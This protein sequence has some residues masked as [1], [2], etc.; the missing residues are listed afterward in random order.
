MEK[1]GRKVLIVELL[2]R[3]NNIKRS[4]YVW[5]AIN[6]MLSALQCPVVLMFVTRI[7]GMKDAGVFSIAFAVSSLMLYIGL[8]GLR[9]FQASDVNEEFRFSDYNGMRFITCGAMMAA[10]L[11][12]CAYGIAFN[13]YSTVK[14]AIVFLVCVL[15]LVQAYTDVIH[16]NMQQKGRLDVAT[17]CSAVRYVLE[18][19]AIIVTMF[20]TGD[21]L[22]S[23]AVSAAVSVTVMMFTSVAAGRK[24]CDT[25]MPRFERKQIRALTID[26]FPLF[27]SLF[28]NMY[29][30]N[31]PKYAIDA[32]LT[33]EI[34]AVYN[35][36]FMPA[37]MVMLLSNFIFNPII[38]S[39]AE[40]W[41]SGSAEQHKELW[42]R[43][44]MQLLF[45]LGL[46]VLGLAV[47]A[48]IGIPML[49]LIFGTDLSDYKNELCIVMI[50][51]GALAYATYFST[52]ITIIREQ[53]SMIICYGIAAAAAYVLSGILVKSYGIMG[54]S[55]MYAII[56]TVLAVL[57]GAITIWDLNK[58]LKK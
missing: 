27:A 14:A 3:T 12:Y 20:I 11:G 55:V 31:A 17:K 15:K 38:K 34:Q 5:N 35:L 10:S 9:R 50:G 33:E 56:M 40:L 13:S 37:F 49:S 57:L 42:R 23:V 28:L 16:G 4:A 51:G 18:V 52:V 46:T 47:A 7:G 19:A 58:K 1:R 24:Y 41:L 44:R 43:I 22:I 21:L 54:A 26:G 48:T 53:K 30:S 8:Y 25:Y 45:V 6:A 32:Y 2:E 36:I 29:I 39:Y